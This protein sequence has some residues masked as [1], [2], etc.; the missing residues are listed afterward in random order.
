MTRQIAHTLYRAS[1]QLLLSGLVTDDVEARLEAEI[2]LGYALG[3][4][5]AG[6]YARLQEPLPAEE[7]DAY[8][9]L[10]AR[11]LAGEPVA[12]ITRQ[13]EFYGLPFYVDRRVLIPRPETELLVERALL[14]CRRTAGDQAAGK[15]L[16]LADVG[17]GSGCIAIALA[18]HLPGAL[19]YAVD[20]SPD[21]LAVTTLNARRHGVAGRVIPLEGDLLTPVPEPLDLIVANLPYVSR[22]HLASLP[23]SITAYEPLS[24][25]DGGADGLELIRRLLPQ[26]GKHLH[27]GGAILLEI[28]SDQAEAVR[29]LALEIFP[30]A[31][32]NLYHDLSGHPR[33]L[34]VLPIAEKDGI[35]PLVPPATEEARSL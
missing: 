7:L 12:Y 10:L 13:R 22:S 29:S 6:L 8:E 21:A 34:E 26:A 4:D 1:Q 28:G 2:L 17:C 32:I 31:C 19:I 11:R 14:L 30:R 9:A 20:I 5:R 33:V 35:I 23:R 16:C 15:R 25:L 24:A 27:Q 18:I 3:L